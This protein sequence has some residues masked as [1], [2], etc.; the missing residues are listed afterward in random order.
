MAPWAAPHPFASPISVVL[1]GIAH[2]HGLHRTCVLS[3]SPPSNG[4]HLYSSSLPLLRLS[5]LRLLYCL[6]LSGRGCSP[7]PEGTLQ[8]LHRALPGHRPTESPASHCAGVH[9]CSQ[10]HMEA[11]GGRPVYFSVILCIVLLM[12]GLTEPWSWA[13]GQETAAGKPT[14]RKMTSLLPTK[15]A[16]TPFF[17]S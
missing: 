17:S 11:R 7:E 6:P 3:W 4:Y 10:T 2:H 5:F 14:V 13:A 1:P 15:P 16:I 12:Q 8:I 9:T